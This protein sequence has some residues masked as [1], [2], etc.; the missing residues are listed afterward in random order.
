MQAKCAVFF[1]PKNEQLRRHFPPTVIPYRMISKH[2]NVWLKLKWQ[3]NFR[4]SSARVGK[5]KPE[6]QN[7][8][9]EK[10]KAKNWKVKTWNPK[11]GKW[12]LE[13][14]KLGHQKTRNK[15]LE[16]KLGNH[17]WETIQTKTGKPTCKRPKQNTQ[18][19]CCSLQQIIKSIFR[20]RWPAVD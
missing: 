18:S 9:S 14:Q 19:S 5:A 10:W 1:F 7:L 16:Q 2:V 12:K 4:C 8:R 11:S 3:A 13:T 6:T 15:K 17:T 20:W